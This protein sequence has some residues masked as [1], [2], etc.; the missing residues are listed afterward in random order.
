VHPPCTGAQRSPAQGTIVVLA[1]GHDRPAGGR[2]RGDRRDTVIGSRRQVD[3]RSI[4]VGQG[5]IQTRSRADRD[6]GRAGAADEFGKP[7]GPDQ[8]VR[9][10]GDRLDQRRV[11][12][13]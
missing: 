1:D 2:R 6:G 12:A 13:R 3:D 4:H 11:S 8:I 9:Q 5:G 7:G 10:D